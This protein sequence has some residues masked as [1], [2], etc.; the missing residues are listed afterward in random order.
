M[1]THFVIGDKIKFKENDGTVTGFRGDKV[2]VLFSF[3]NHDIP[4]DPES[5][6]LVSKKEVFTEKIN[7]VNQPK[8]SIDTKRADMLISLEALRFGL[9]PWGHVKDLTI[10]YE[11]IEKWASRY[12]PTK[13]SDSL[14]VSEIRC[15]L[16]TSDAADEEDS[17]D[18]GG[19]RII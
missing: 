4:I 12:F 15:L 14:T 13:Q 1:P 19:R 5:I 11:E 6:V 7:E 3:I 17:V 2:M 18:L 9:V 8:Q 16:Y 10:G